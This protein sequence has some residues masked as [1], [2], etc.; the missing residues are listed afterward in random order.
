MAAMVNEFVS[1][2]DPKLHIEDDFS[3]EVDSTGLI[4]E[5]T[6]GS[7]LEVTF[8]KKRGKIMNY[9][10]N[11]IT[12]LPNKGKEII[13]LKRVVARPRQTELSEQGCS[14]W[15]IEEETPFG[16]KV[17]KDNEMSKERKALKKKKTVLMKTSSEEMGH[18]E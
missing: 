10:R 11:T 8:A 18:P 15:S 16:E 2:K 5:H 3:P 7:K 9:S 1:E 14:K 17:T 4:G 6:K 12:I 13:L